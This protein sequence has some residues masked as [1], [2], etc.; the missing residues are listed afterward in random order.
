MK[1]KFNST[2]H[3]FYMQ[4]RYVNLSFTITFTQ[5]LLSTLDFIVCSS[6]E[7]IFHANERD[8]LLREVMHSLHRVCLA[9]FGS[10]GAGSCPCYATRFGEESTLFSR[11]RAA[12]PQWV[13]GKLLMIKVNAQSEEARFS[14]SP[15]F[16]LPFFSLLFSFSVGRARCKDR[17]GAPSRHMS[18]HC[19]GNNERWPLLSAVVVPLLPLTYVRVLYKQ[20]PT[21]TAA[22]CRSTLI[23]Y[24]FRNSVAPKAREN[25]CRV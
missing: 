22:V 15:S 17:R 11:N 20:P 8:I 5:L 13:A 24:T 4:I 21:T 6:L 7:F 12:A 16:L 1:I 10:L 14:S 2:D 23:N 19:C 9:T 18:V 3:L 25:R